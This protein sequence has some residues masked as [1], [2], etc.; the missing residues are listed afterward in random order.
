MV[1]VVV[2]HAV[3][4]VPW[5]SEGLREIYADCAVTIGGRAALVIIEARDVRKVVLTTTES[6]R[7][8]RG[9]TICVGEFKLSQL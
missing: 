6:I 1:L 5:R 9:L 3:V 2:P 7:P 8:V 4:D